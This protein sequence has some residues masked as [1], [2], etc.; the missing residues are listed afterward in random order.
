MIIIQSIFNIE[1]FGTGIQNS[2]IVNIELYS[3][4]YPIAY[5]GKIEADLISVQNL[6]NP[7]II[8]LPKQ[9]QDSKG[10]CSYFDDKLYTWKRLSCTRNTELDKLVEETSITC[11]TPHLT[12]FAAINPV[13]YDSNEKRLSRNFKISIIPS[14]VILLLLVAPLVLMKF[15][16]NREE[17]DK[18][19]REPQP[20]QINNTTNI[21]ESSKSPNHDEVSEIEISPAKMNPNGGNGSEV[22]AT[23]VDN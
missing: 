9:N 8:S 14:L 1:A 7:I 13:F 17:E 19:L 2:D 5:N 23:I 10:L 6:E 11:C 22:V 21:D 16:K 20:K 15:S 12:S 4:K 18:D 3:A